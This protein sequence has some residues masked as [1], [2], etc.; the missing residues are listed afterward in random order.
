VACEKGFSDIVKAIL[1]SL[2]TTQPLL[3]V[4]AG[5]RNH[6]P[7][8]IACKNGHIGVVKEILERGA[9]KVDVRTE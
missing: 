9:E 5:S 6:S 3:D 2:T 4:N 7:L 1:L 8:I